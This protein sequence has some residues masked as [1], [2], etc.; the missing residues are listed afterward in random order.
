MPRVKRADPFKVWG[1]PPPSLMRGTTKRQQRALR[2]YVNK[3]ANKVYRLAY[4]L[5]ACRE[6]HKSK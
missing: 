5:G 4:D 2:R 3:I 6:V 1:S